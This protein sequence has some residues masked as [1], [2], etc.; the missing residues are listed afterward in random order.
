MII[1]AGKEKTTD[2]W[3]THIEPDDERFYNI[4]AI[5]YTPKTIED[6]END[7]GVKIVVSI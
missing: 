6:I 7:Y 4:K 1:Y 3:F 5:E 2:N